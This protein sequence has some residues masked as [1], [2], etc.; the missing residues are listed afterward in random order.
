MNTAARRFFIVVLCLVTVACALPAGAAEQ[1]PDRSPWTFGIE[2]GWSK[3]AM[4][5]INDVI[6]AFNEAYGDTVDG[7]INA[8]LSDIN[9]GMEFGLTVDRRISSVLTVGLGYTHLDGSTDYPN[10]TGAFELSVG[11]NLWRGYVHYIPKMDSGMSWGAGLDLGVISTTGDINLAIPG[12]GTDT[13]AFEGSAPAGAGYLIV[14]FPGTRTVSFQGHFGY[15]VATITDVTLAGTPANAD[16]DY[17]GF[18]LRAAFLL[19]P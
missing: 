3:F 8:V 7:K 18:F 2:L 19:H 17:T 13:G 16:L 14:D 12:E 15:R 4:D 10:P 5:D 1:Y 11:A 6:G 9:G